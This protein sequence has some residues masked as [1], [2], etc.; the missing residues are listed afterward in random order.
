MQVIINLFG[1]IGLIAVCYGYYHLLL[2]MSI[3]VATGSAIQLYDTYN[4]WDLYNLCVALFNTVM[5]LVLI[6][7]QVTPMS[8][9]FRRRS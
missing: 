3:F 2:L 5:A 6:R 7:D 8:E 4:G 9:Y 1:I